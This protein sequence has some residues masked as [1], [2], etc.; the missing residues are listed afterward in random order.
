MA[1]HLEEILKKLEPLMEKVN[2][3]GGDFLRTWDRTQEELDALVLVAQALQEFY[4]K[5]VSCRVFEGNTAMSIFRDQSTRTRSSFVSACSML[6]LPV[7][8]MDESKSQIAH[9]ETVRETA[10]MLS[11]M[12]EVI[13]IRD[14]MYLGEGH[15]YELE[16]A[17]TVKECHKEG[18]LPQPTCVVNLQC[19]EDHPTQ[20]TADLLHLIKHFGG[21]ENLRGKKLVMSW[22]YSPSY[23]K[24]LSVPQSIIALMT[25]Y[26]M[27][28]TLA[29]PEG[30]D[31][32][33][34]IVD[35][36]RK[37][38]EESGG[39]F[40]VSHDMKESFKDAD[41]VYPKS[42]ASIPVMQERIQLLRA[43]AASSEAIKELDKRAI[44]ES[45]KYIDWTCTQELMDVTKDGKALYMHCL[46]ADIS[47]VSCERGEVTADV[48]EKARIPTYNEAGNKPY[49][50]AAMILLCRFP[51]V[52]NLLREVQKRNAPRVFMRK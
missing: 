28:V 39:K 4:K 52:L 37:N 30:Y 27:D 14:D 10:A 36:A 16:V 18:V 48:F 41:V 12:T 17:E 46:P 1:D 42:W 3:Y 44:E 35:I 47:G 31:L 21:V 7:L 6:G 26:G 29:H 50:I 13:G 34:E 33:P 49:T 43:G 20:A 51:N 2:T 40:T 19:D 15:K 38:A 24:P 11:F 45:K 22:A 23:G 25:R 32:L 8:D 9:G 5:N